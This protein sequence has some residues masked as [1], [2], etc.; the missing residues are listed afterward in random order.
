[1]SKGWRETPAQVDLRASRKLHNRCK[2]DFIRRDKARAEYEKIVAHIKRLS[3]L[4][5]MPANRDLWFDI[6]KKDLESKG[7]I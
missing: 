7:M 2:A 1:M 3:E 5:L 6:A 4:R